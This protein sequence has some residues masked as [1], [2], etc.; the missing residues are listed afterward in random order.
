MDDSILLIDLISGVC[1][2]FPEIAMG[3]L[4]KCLLGA[5]P[6]TYTLRDMIIPRVVS[7]SSPRTKMI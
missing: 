3:L 6:Y 7:K 5:S 4:C 1:G 2:K